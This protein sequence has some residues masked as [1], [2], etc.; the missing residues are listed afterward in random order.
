MVISVPKHYPA[1]IT[2]DNGIKQRS[3]LTVANKRVADHSKAKNNL[4]VMFEWTIQECLNLC[5][6]A[7]FLYTGKIHTIV[8]VLD[9]DNWHTLKDKFHQL[10]KL[11]NC[12]EQAV[13]P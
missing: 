5:K 10:D 8:Q 2:D 1:C 3:N 7:F 9:F 6:I 4:H 11:S 13:G 12:F